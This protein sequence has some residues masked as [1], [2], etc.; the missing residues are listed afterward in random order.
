MTR[1]LQIIIGLISTLLVC[2]ING[3]RVISKSF[4]NREKLQNS[5]EQ[6]SYFHNK[7][8]RSP[9]SLD[10]AP[11]APIT[12][13]PPATADGT[14]LPATTTQQETDAGR[15]D[16]HEHGDDHHVVMGHCSMTEKCEP[17]QYCDGTY[18][19]KCRSAGDHCDL[20]GECCAGSE[21]QYGICEKG[22]EA[23]APG[24]FCDLAKDCKGKETCCIHEISISKH[25]SVCKPMLET[26][27]SCGPINLFHQDVLKA[28]MEPVCGPCK[29]GLAC[30]GVGILGRHSICLP[31]DE[32]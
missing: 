6:N 4:R 5:D 1:H 21:C 30:K 9:Q 10:G 31:E 23:G 19:F 16:G 17:D 18:C 20:N 28:S 26:H 7:Q 14:N 24:T 32:E 25:H 11:V 2:T 3:E 15:R 29:S 22:V 12:D 8:K 27:E 13:P